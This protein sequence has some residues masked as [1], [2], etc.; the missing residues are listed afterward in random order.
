MKAIPFIG[1][2]LA[3]WAVPFSMQAQSVAGYPRVMQGPMLGAVSED[4]ALVWLRASWKWPVQLVYGTDPDLTDAR[5]TPVFMPE[6]EADYCLTIPIEG[7]DADTVYYYAIRIDDGVD[8]YLDGRLP[9]HFKTAP[10]PGQKGRFS[11]AYGSCAR[12][13]R[14]PLQPIWQVLPEWNPDLFFWLGDNVYADTL[15]PDILAEEFQRQR[16]VAGLQPILPNV[17]QLAIWDDHDFG[18]NN[19]DRTN[20]MKEQNLEVWKRYWPNPSH[21]LPDVPGIFFKYAYGGVDFFFLDGR[22]YRDPNAM[23]DGPDKTMLGEG[24]VNWLKKELAASEAPFK[25]LV[26]GGIWTTAKGSE[27]D[28]WSAFLHERNEL[29]DWIRDAGIGGVVLFSGDTHTGEL[30]VI[31]WSDHGGYD[32]YDLTASPLAQEGEDGWVFRNVEMRLRLP[33]SL[34]PNFGLVEFDLSGDEP[35]LTFKLI[36]LESKP[37]WAPLVLRAGELVNGTQ[38]WPDKQSRAAARWMEQ[39]ASGWEDK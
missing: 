27:G 17:P 6:K 29:F 39:F 2:F 3:I 15:D 1:A 8:K 38:S 10:D 35:T 12:W 19:H 25:V 5:M 34:G 16:E 31:P 4:S 33:Y 26:S 32:L 30:N 24:Q 23:P 11:V 20:P 14:D 13:Q 9:F 36:G 37:V 22:Y 21:G 18:L 28:A 7:L